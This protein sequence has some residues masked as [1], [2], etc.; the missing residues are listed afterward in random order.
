MK[1]IYGFGVYGFLVAVSLLLPGLNSWMDVY[2]FG[3]VYFLMGI[4]FLHLWYVAYQ[5]KF[6]ETMTG[7]SSAENAAD[8]QLATVLSI[9]IV[10][11]VV[12]KIL[13]VF[14]WKISL[15]LPSDIFILL[16]VLY[17]KVLDMGAI[18]RIQNKI[19]GLSS[20]ISR[21]N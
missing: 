11:V 15:I 8:A 12:I 21:E 20:Q 6:T 4:S 17:V 10:I 14:L 18:A 5:L 3:T 1:R 9:W 16:G 2:V 19:Q 13:M 7:G